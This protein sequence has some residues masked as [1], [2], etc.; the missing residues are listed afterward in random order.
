MDRTTSR[1]RFLWVAFFVAVTVIAWSGQAQAQYYASLTS[2]GCP[3][4]YRINE[5]F[6]CTPVISTN[7]PAALQVGM[8]YTWTGNDGLQNNGNNNLQW[9]IGSNNQKTINLSVQYPNAGGITTGTVQQSMTDAATVTVAMNCPTTVLVGLPFTCNP[10]VTTDIPEQYQAGATKAWSNF[11]PVQNPDGTLYFTRVNYPVLLQDITW[12]T[13]TYPLAGRSGFASQGIS[14]IAPTAAIS[15]LGCPTT[16]RVNE[17][18]TCSPTITTN[19]WEEYQT[20]KIV[21]WSG[22]NLQVN[23]NGSMQFTTASNTAKQITLTV[24]YPNGG[25]LTATKNESMTDATT[26]SVS[27]SCPG[28]ALLNEKFTCT[29]T[30]NTDIP[31]AL[32]V[33]ATMT[34]SGQGLQVNGDGTLQFTMKDYFMGNYAIYTVNYP[35]A[36]RSASAQQTVEVIPPSLFVSATGCPTSYRVN[37]PFTCSPVIQTSIPE[38]YQAGKIETWTGTDLQVNA[39]GSLQFTKGS[40]TAKS[41]TYTLKYPNAGNISASGASNLADA[42]TLSITA[43]NCPTTVPKNGPFTCNPTINTDI[44][45]SLRA[46]AVLTYAG[47]YLQVNANGTL[48]FTGI[49]S[50]FGNNVGYTVNYPLAG[51]SANKTQGVTVFSPTAT[52][53]SLNCPADRMLNEKFT[54]SPAITTNI[55]QEFQAGAVYAWTGVNLQINADGSMQWTSAGNRSIALKI[56]YPNANNLATAQVAQAMTVVDPQITITSV[57]CPAVP[58]TG[59]AFTCA[60][61][62]QT[63]LPAS[64]QADRT[65][66]WTSEGLSVGAAESLTYTTAGVKTMNLLVRYPSTG[67]ERTAEQSLTAINQPIVNIRSFGCPPDGEAIL[68]T[69]FQCN[70]VIETNIPAAIQEGRKYTWSASTSGI[71]TVDPNDGGLT[72]TSAGTKGLTLKVEYPLANMS[73]TKNESLRIIAPYITISSMGCP[74]N[75]M[76][77]EPF[78]CSPVTSVNVAESFQEGRVIT[79]SGDGLV[80][81]ANGSMRYDTAGGKVIIMEVKY[82]LISA[83]KT[84]SAK[85]TVGDPT[86]KI[87]SLGCPT[88]WT[89]GKPFTCT[90][91]LSTNLSETYKQELVY[92]WTGEGLTNNGDGTLTVASAGSTTVSLTLTHPTLVGISASNIQTVNF[93]QPSLTVTALNCPTS[94]I[95]GGK[96]TCTPSIDTNVPEAQRSSFR[97]TWTGDGLVNNADGTLSFSSAGSKTVTLEVNYDQGGI[98]DTSAQPMNVIAPQT[99][100]SSLGCPST[101]LIQQKITCTPVITTNLPEKTLTWSA[102][103]M[104]TNADGTLTFSTPGSKTV[105]LS[106]SY[107]GGGVDAVSSTQSMTVENVNI[108][109]SSLGCPSSVQAQESFTCTPVMT[110]DMPEAFK[111]DVKLKWWASGI[112]VSSDGSISLSNIGTVLL[113]L[114]AEI[115]GMSFKQTGNIEVTTSDTVI[116]SLGCPAQITL[117]TP[118]TCTPTIATNLSEA[119][120]ANLQYAWSGD[121]LAVSGSDMSFTTSGS[122]KTITLKVTNPSSGRSIQRSEGVYLIS[123]VISISSLGCPAKIR[124]DYSFSCTPV[125][126]TNMTETEAAKIVYTWSG[127][128]LTQDNGAFSFADPG[129]VP[130]TLTATHPDYPDATSQKTQQMS[131]TTVGAKIVKLGCPTTLMEYRSFTC[132]PI[133]SIDAITALHPEQVTYQWKVSGQSAGGTKVLSAMS[134]NIGELPVELYVKVVDP[135]SGKTLSES[136]MEGYIPVSQNTNPLRLLVVGTRAATAGS[137]VSLEAR[138]SF[139]AENIM[140]YTWTVGGREYSGKAIQI[141]VPRAQV[142]SIPFSVK[143]KPNC[144]TAIAEEATSG[145][146]YVRPYEF[147]NLAVTGPRKAP[148]NIAPY[149]AL[150]KV[151]ASTTADMTFTWDFGDGTSPVVSDTVKDTLSRP[152]SSITHTYEHEGE[153]NVTLTAT[154]PYGMNK[155]VNYLAYVYTLP[156]RDLKITG[157]YSNTYLR[158]PLTGYFKYAISGGLLVDSPISNKWSVN[159]ETVSEKSTAA[160]LFPEAGTYNVGLQVKTKYGNTINVT[161]AVTVQPNTRPTCSIGQTPLDRS[162]YMLTANCT[163]PDGKIIAYRWE[164]PNGATGSSVRAY[165]TLKSAGSYPVKVTVTDDSRET[166]TVNGTVVVE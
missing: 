34:Y 3:A 88:S 104:V 143:A 93:I 14:V 6:T 118:F 73:V 103:G 124:E 111:P 119:E 83:T 148:T 57:N 164:L 146:I 16:Y 138:T 132:S 117:K 67:L 150:F 86:L 78:T 15:S 163:D 62:I 49:D 91:V 43:L 59:K 134:G 136:T 1:I 135:D 137:S 27:L 115:N 126:T 29:P 25:N 45:E 60:P 110:M 39:D 12:Y 31:E 41:I 98:G 28:T 165:V 9:T 2:T 72:F 36:G 50:F 90:P 56:T 129:Y 105:T 48:Q 154:D 160:I 139:Q 65:Y 153:Y 7:I 106:V 68:N 116:T 8:V 17:P 95:T 55:P 21:T 122:S 149:D 97:Y 145:K 162:V 76:T 128:G 74:A 123:P 102:D 46:G 26:L 107:P 84:Q 151:M 133:M 147:P 130:L 92:S 131:V 53:N 23:A 32:R 75:S 79:W 44:P 69:K 152:T 54:C 87:S 157:V 5:A 33:G 101:T 42:A 109:I 19:L 10:T 114:T 120:K 4:T 158:S 142:D 82:P 144:C 63:N 155:R 77:N 24:K 64:R 51:R 30:V 112:N 52:I 108:S 125:I 61:V 35:L 121:G 140:Q 80:K 159:G 156:T 94:G 47:S 66:T 22:D 38:S 11:A 127:T 89:P 13:V 166:T 113:T 161:K 71:M 85:I 70:P 20:G 99:T 18:F 100:I 58:V 81:N 96:F 40:N 37:E 141:D